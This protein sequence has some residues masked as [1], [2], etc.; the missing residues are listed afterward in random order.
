MGV[1]WTY[2]DYLVA[3]ARMDEAAVARAIDEGRIVLVP[4]PHCGAETTRNAID[5]GEH[6]LAC[7]PV[8]ERYFEIRDPFAGV[9][10]AYGETLGEAVENAYADLSEEERPAYVWHQ[11][12]QVPVPGGTCT[13]LG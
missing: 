10:D 2:G 11:G 13:P 7:F 4:C 12:Q 3:T 9:V 5:S 6:E 8:V 1:S